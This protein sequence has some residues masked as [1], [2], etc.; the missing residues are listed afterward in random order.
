MAIV[1][2]EPFR[3]VEQMRREMDRM[4]D[5]IFRGSRFMAPGGDHQP[6]LPSV[7]LVDTEKE[8][9]LK[10]DLPG[11]EAK[12]L[13]IEANANEISIKGERKEEK[14]VKKE[15]YYYHERSFGSFSRV[16]PFPAEIR[17]EEVKSTFKNGVLEIT[18]AKAV[19]SKP[20]LPV[21][22]PITQ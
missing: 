4:F 20:R 8:Y 9:R 5:V 16:I 2:W 14:E 19:P 17:P 12:D 18:A 3:E 7:D 21:K 11:L 1:K 6:W 22:V 10:I 13:E 15:N